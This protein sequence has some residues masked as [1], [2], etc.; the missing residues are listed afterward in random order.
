MDRFDYST[1]TRAMVETAL[2]YGVIDGMDLLTM[3]GNDEEVQQELIN[4]AYVNRYNASDAHR[5]L[6]SV[7]NEGISR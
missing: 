3:S 2:N 1:L 7:L 5:I 4:I 6:V